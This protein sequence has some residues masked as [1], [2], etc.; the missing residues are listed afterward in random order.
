MELCISVCLVLDSPSNVFCVR[1]C[2]FLLFRA[3]RL[4]QN[5]SEGLWQFV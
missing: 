3:L 4:T 1:L 5:C 2:A